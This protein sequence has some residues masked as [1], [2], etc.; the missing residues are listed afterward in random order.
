VP[1]ALGRA[2]DGAL[3]GM[4]V[5]PGDP[6]ALAEALRR[7]LSQSSTRDRIKSAA[8]ARRATLP[9]WEVTTSTLASILERL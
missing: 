1:E 3:P 9:G 4:L 7:W 8:L 2:P 6:S 5:P